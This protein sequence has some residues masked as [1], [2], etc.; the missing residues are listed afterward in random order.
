MP[1][2]HKSVTDVSAI[3]IDI[4]KTTFHLIG[5]DRRG[6]IVMR[7]RL[8]R[9]QFLERLANVPRCLIG[10]EAGAGAHHIAR[11]LLELGHDV[12]LIPA[13]YVKPFLKGHKNDY[14]DAEAIIEAVQRP[15]MSF[16][17]VKTA[18]QCDLQALH[19]VRSR[20]VRL[21]TG[22]INQIRGLLLER[23]ITIAQR[24]APL[25]KALP[26]ILADPPSH[27]SPRVLRLIG[28]LIEEL[29]R[30][31]DRIQALTQEIEVLAAEDDAC[32][33]LMTVPGIGPIISS[34]V[35]S[36]IGTGGG[37]RQG[38]DFAAWLGLVPRQFSTGGRTKL[39]GLSKRGNCYLRTLFVQAAH[40]ILIKKPAAAQAGLWPWIERA[41]KRMAHRNLLATALANKLARIAWAVLAGGHAYRPIASG[42]RA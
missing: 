16:V 24:T 28:S 41:A 1:S 39:G 2:H 40:V 3:G 5:Q 31:E 10:M 14:R 8:S 25:R 36:A 19:R 4:G 7:A 13:Q 34:A 12:R 21:R 27:I 6:K 38:R 32:Q 9:S 30:L 15:T 22:T 37:F 20:L 23:G 11:R 26:K 29:N 33:R 35:V 17:A 18:E 42:E